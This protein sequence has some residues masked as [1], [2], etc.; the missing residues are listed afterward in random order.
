[1][2]SWALFSVVLSQELKQDRNESNISVCKFQHGPLKLR[3]DRPKKG[4]GTWCDGDLLRSRIQ[5]SLRSNWVRK[6]V[7]NMSRGG[8]WVWGRYSSLKAHHKGSVAYT[9]K[10]EA[11][12]PGYI[13]VLYRYTERTIGN[14][15][16]YEDIAQTMNNKSAVDTE[17]Q[18]E[19]KFNRYCLRCWFILN[20]GKEKS[21][22]EK[23]CLST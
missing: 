6:D 2:V 16:R 9:E 5:T 3:R 10:L 4:T 17:G 8:I 19:T 7:D 1:M 11:E 13:H 22:L 21:P 15:L 20:G 14:Q 18:R 12:Y 23:P